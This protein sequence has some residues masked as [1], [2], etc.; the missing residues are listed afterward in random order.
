RLFSS[1]VVDR[2]VIQR[3]PDRYCRWTVWPGWPGLTWP[4]KRTCRWGLTLAAANDPVIACRTVTFSARLVAPQYT[5]PSPN[6]RRYS[7]LR[8]GPREKLILPVDEV[9]P[10][11]NVVHVVLPAGRACSWT[12]WFGRPRPVSVRSRVAVS[13]A[14]PPYLIVL[15][16]SEADSAVVVSF[17]F[18]VGP[19]PASLYGVTANV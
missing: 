17:A 18:F 11:V 16:A 7:W 4:V 12:F 19:A 13:L 5:E 8:A 10:V 6:T 3:P 2:D 1:S 9:V 14:F 15:G